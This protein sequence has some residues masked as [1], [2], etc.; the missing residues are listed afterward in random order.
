MSASGSIESI[1]ISKVSR[2]QPQQVASATLEAGKGIVGDR[3]HERA[4]EFLAA[5]DDVQSN[6]ISLISKEE[7]DSFLQN[8]DAEIEHRNFR[9]NVLTSGIDLNSLIGKQFTLGGALCE[10]VE[11]CAPCA[12]LA[13]TVHRAVLPELNEKA[14]L[15]AIILESGE[16]KPGDTITAIGD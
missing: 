11:E 15:R 8:N 5:G 4:L 16:I 14:G 12:F 3:Y 10:G 1:F 7:L 6:H 9:R 2:E 13:A